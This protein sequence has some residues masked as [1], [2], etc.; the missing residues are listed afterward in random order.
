MWDASEKDKKNIKLKVEFQYDDSTIPKSKSPEKSSVVADTEN[1]RNK[2]GRVAADSNSS[3][4]TS[5]TENVI[6]DN[7]KS[8]YE[9]L[10][11]KYDAVVEYTVHLTAERDTIV[12]QL[13][14]AQK[15]LSR[16]ITKRRI[17]SST[18][19]DNNSKQPIKGGKI[20]EKVEPKVILSDLF[21]LFDDRKSVSCRDFL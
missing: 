19:G 7:I 16:E 4:I 8:E 17:A 11:K 10:K 5:A 20:S 9:I 14:E 15:D 12:T 18:A 1:I 2:I 3:N 13:E 6:Q 21:R